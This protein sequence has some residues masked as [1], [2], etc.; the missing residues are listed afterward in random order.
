[1]NLN[2]IHNKLG[3]IQRG[4]ADNPA[5]IFLLVAGGIALLVVGGILVDAL[6][7]KASA[8]LQLNREKKRAK[9]RTTGQWPLAR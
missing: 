1:M 3:V 6:M 5:L 8:H 7:V 2:S 9:S 4:F